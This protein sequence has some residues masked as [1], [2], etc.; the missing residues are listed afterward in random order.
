M[1][2][3]QWT[4]SWPGGGQPAGLQI[5][6][7]RPQITIIVTS[8]KHYENSV[9]RAHT[10][11]NQ[12]QHTRKFR[13][14]FLHSLRKKTTQS[15]RW[16]T[17]W[18]APFFVTSPLVWFLCFFFRVRP[19]LFESLCLGFFLF[20]FY[21]FCL[22]S[23]FC[24]FF[25]F[26]LFFVFTVYFLHLLLIIRLIIMLHILLL[27]LTTIHLHL[28]CLYLLLLPI[29]LMLLLTHKPNSKRKQ[30]GKTDRCDD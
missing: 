19:Y 30:T 20:F 18:P 1:T 21:L 22:G 28:L 8:T 14:L 26:F 6:V 16:T 25:F 4:T 2:K 7:F 9:F 11:K 24:F 17:S 29:L 3:K 10:Q 5:C 12:L 23:W 15:D 13:H 27:L